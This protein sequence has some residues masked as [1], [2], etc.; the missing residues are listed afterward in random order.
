[1]SIQIHKDEIRLRA[2]ELEPST[3]YSLKNKSLRKLESRS[4]ISDS[5]Y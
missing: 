1:M 5:Y 4:K 3:Y 2:K